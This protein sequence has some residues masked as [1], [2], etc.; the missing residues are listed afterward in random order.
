MKRLAL[1]GALTVEVRRWRDHA[2]STS[3]GSKRPRRASW[4]GY[5]DALKAGGRVLV[6]ADGGDAEP[7]AVGAQPARRD[8]HPCRL[9]QHRRRS[10]RGH[11][12]HHPAVSVDDGGG[13]RM[14]LQAAEMILRPV[15]SEKSM[16]ETQRGKYTFRVHSDA[17]KLMVKDGDRGALQGQRHQ[18]QRPDDQGQG[19]VAQPQARPRRGLDLALEEGRRDAGQP[20]RRSNSSRGSRRCRC[21][22]TSQPPPAAVSRHGRRS[23]RSPPTEPHKPLLEAAAAHQ[24]PQQPGPHDGSPSRRRREALLPAHR[25]Q[26]RQVDVPAKLATVEYD[27]NRSA[28]IG[29]LHYARRREALHARAQRPERG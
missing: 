5:L 29:L 6:V 28:R 22:P 4:S 24:R 2:W 26:A 13:V 20:A 8:G 25:L 1:H 17:N 18:R 10:Q 7:R 23:R 15:I 16:D 12:A 3:S 27:P 21:V 9:A 19:E 11:A 14:T